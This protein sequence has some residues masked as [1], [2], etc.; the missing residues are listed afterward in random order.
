M[1]GRKKCW[2]AYRGKFS[3]LKSNG[4][5]PRKSLLARDYLYLLE[6]DKDVLTCENCPLGVHYIHAGESHILVPDLRVSRR[7]SLQL[8]KLGKRPNT[9]ELSRVDRV[10]DYNLTILT[11]PEVKQQPS[12]NCHSYAAGR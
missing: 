7:D 12:L 8:V 3:A 11:E 10:E 1:V 9:G 2:S 6:F 4:S 5:V